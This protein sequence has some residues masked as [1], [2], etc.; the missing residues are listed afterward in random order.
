MLLNDL[1][2]L[3]D[4]LDLID[5]DQK[6]VNYFNEMDECEII[7]T[8]MLL[9]N[10]YISEN[11]TDI[12]E[13]DFHEKMIENVRE[14]Y[15]PLLI[16]EIFN[17]VISPCE[18]EELMEDLD[19][20]MEIA[21][22]IFYTQIIP[23]RSFSSTF[24]RCIPTA[25]KIQVLQYKLTTLKNKPQ[26]QQRTEDWYKFRY[27]LIT[28]SNAYKAFEN[29]TVQNQLI[30]EKCQPLRM[31][32]EKSTFVNVESPLHWGQKY[33]PLSVMYYEQEYNT[34]IGDFGCIQHDTY[35]FLGASPDGINNDP[36]RPAR[37]GRMLEIKNI[38]NREIDGIPKK[39]Y[40]IQM[41]LQ[42][43]TCDLDE[44]DFLETRFVEY[45]CE[46][47]FLKDGKE[48]NR[49]DA[50]QLKGV[51]MYFSTNEGMPHYVYKPLSMGLEEFEEWSEKKID[52]LCA[53]G[54]GMCWIKNIFWKLV[55]V[56]CVLVLRNKVW[57]KDNIHQLKHIWSIIERERENWE[58]IQ[59]APNKRVK[60]SDELI[61]V[62]KIEN[63]F[64]L[65][66]NF[67]LGTNCTMEK[68]KSGSG[69]LLPT[70]KTG[71]Q[72][73]SQSHENKKVD[74]DYNNQTIV[75][76]NN[77]YQE[78]IKIIKIRTEPIDETKQNNTCV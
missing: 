29:Q 10:D 68:E 71:L 11:P 69:C 3:E 22:S 41:Q 1:D 31:N 45:E 56:S 60:K 51:I 64:N 18:R 59:R 8:C 17:G 72:I 70:S 25:E 30:Y 15:S 52:D 16:P 49:T 58:F 76:S 14:M 65:G 66:D 4:I 50:N 39:E 63:Y 75:Q 34:R 37:F 73:Q 61:N 42:M 38:V 44:C 77:Q 23:P 36:T 33:E 55:E 47:Y 5:V 54:M 13:P 6:N 46:A 19:E 57:F 35:E 24:I 62:N 74:I 32:N 48:F 9:M 53:N 7:E 67:N 12:S 2:E 21:S 43:E 26:P 40:W 20:L 28:A 27:N 78:A